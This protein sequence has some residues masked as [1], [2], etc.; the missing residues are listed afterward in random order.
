M[1]F[2]KSLLLLALVPALALTSCYH[3]FPSGGGGGGGTGTGTVIVTVTSTPSQTF[4]FPYLSWE[5][6]SIVL[7]TGAGA[8]A[9]VLQAPLPITDFARLQTDTQLLNTNGAAV[10]IAAASY[11]S[12]KIQLSPSTNSSYFYNST[13]A[14]LFGCAVGAVCQLP[15]TVPGF[16]S[17]TVTVP[18]TLTV[19]ANQNTGFSLNFDLSKAVTT[20]GGMTFDFTKTGAITLATLPRLGQVS[21]SLDLLD[22]FTGTIT[23][24]S[25]SALTITMS[26]LS[27][28]SRT[29]TVPGVAEFDD[30]FNICQGSANFSCFAIGQ[31][32]SLDCNINAKGTVT[33]Y[34]VDF[35]DPAPGT[36]EIEGIIVSPLNNSNQFQM[37]ITNGMG[38]AGLLPGTLAT[39]TLSN[40]STYFID[41]KTLSAQISNVAAP[42]FQV[43][44]DLVVGQDVMLKGATTNFGTNGLSNYSQTLLRYS[45]IN[46]TVGT[47]SAELFTLT[48]LSPFYA[49]STTNT[50]QAEAFPLTTFDN[51]SGFPTTGN[52]ISVR[53]IYLNPNSGATDILL[54]AK[55]RGH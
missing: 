9:A 39:V 22:N 1:K 47:V 37:V 2:Y 33:A 7:L 51:I 31:N 4:Y 54:V 20:A 28:D 30:P 23:A 49:S 27:S 3:E 5:I 19:A 15:N 13:N 41:P 45:S 6:T 36:N 40:T 17:T 53:G 52:N 16:G 34:E 35:I 29:I 48:G 42:G 12:A 14:T 11:T 18:I 44:T 50:V 21:G 10:S 43:S 32:V 24:T 38:A 46:G 55:I 25:P 26:S 8:S